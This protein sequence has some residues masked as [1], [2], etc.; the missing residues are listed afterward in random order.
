[1]QVVSNP[2]DTRSQYPLTTEQ[3]AERNR[4][5]KQTVQA[6]YSKTGHWYGI[7]P[8]KLANGRVFWPDAIATA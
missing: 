1:M 5:K 7:R 3:F 6:R 2:G 4:V 8:L